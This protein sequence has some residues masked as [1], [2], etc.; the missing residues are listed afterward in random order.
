MF[1]HLEGNGPSRGEVPAESGYRTL[2]WNSD[3]RPGLLRMRV[4]WPGKK[5]MGEADEQGN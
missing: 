4:Q 2:N 5:K 1:R 3:G